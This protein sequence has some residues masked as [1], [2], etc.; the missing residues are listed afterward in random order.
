MRI[1]N[2]IPRLNLLI[3]V[4]VFSSCAQP[5]N[6]VPT[7]LTATPIAQSSIVSPTPAAADTASAAPTLVMVPTLPADEAAKRWVDLLSNNGGCLLP[8]LWGI[9]P[10]RSTEQEALA[11]LVP[12]ESISELGGFA[13]GNGSLSLYYIEDDLQINTS[14]AYL[15]NNQTVSRIVFKARIL[16]KI[17]AS[18]GEPGFSS[19]FDASPLGKYIKDYMLPSILSQLGVPTS[20]VISTLAN[21]PSPTAD[22]GFDIVVIYPE[23]GVLAHYKTQRQLVGMMIQGCFTNNSPVELEL[24]PLGD[25]ASFSE[26]LA[27]TSWAGFWPGPVDTPYWKPLEKATDLSIE[28]F[29]DMFR[30]SAGECILTPATLW[31]SL[32][33]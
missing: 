30:K 12:L 21:P 28:E 11:I 22:G 26:E 32:E 27:S 25:S 19:V 14:T 5:I 9:T 13:P 23:L 18:N 4:I 1:Q 33:Q 16:K 10:G 31:P 29:Y 7:S 2:A 8:C 24:F 15:S 3:L 20:V 17:I 6:G